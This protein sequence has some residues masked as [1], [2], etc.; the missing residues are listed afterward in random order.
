MGN[1]RQ[2]LVSEMMLV[3]DESQKDAEKWLDK[4]FE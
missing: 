3:C 4:F 1:A 2:I